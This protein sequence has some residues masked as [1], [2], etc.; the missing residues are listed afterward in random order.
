MLFVSI[1]N[2]TLF[3]FVIDTNSQLNMTR[4][5]KRLGD[6]SCIVPQYKII[7]FNGIVFQPT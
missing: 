7:V 2:N 3:K 6:K 4:E 1:L 5:L